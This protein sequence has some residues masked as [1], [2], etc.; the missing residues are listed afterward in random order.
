MKRFREEAVKMFMVLMF[1]LLPLYYSDNYYDILDDKKYIFMLFA[2]ILIVAVAACFVVNMIFDLKKKQ[3]GNHIQAEI[4]SIS[5][6][7]VLMVLFSVIAVISLF[8]A[9]D[10]DMAFSGG[11]AWDVGAYAIV[12]GMIVYFI[13][14]RCFSG[15]ADVWAY[16][17][18]GSF[19]VLLIGV[20]DRLGYDFLVMH[21]EIPLQYN[22]FIS[23]IGNVNFWAAYL[24]MIVPFFMLAPVFIKSR[25][26]RFLTYVFLLTAYFSLFITLTNTTYLGIG[27][28]ALFVIWFSFRDTKRLKN[29]AANGI[30]FTM[31]GAVAEVLWKHPEMTA[32]PIDTDSVSLLLLQHRLYLIPG[33]AGVALFMILFATGELSEE[34]RAK[35][36]SVTEKYIPAVWCLAVLAGVIAACIYLARHYSLELLNYRGSIWYF[37]FHG[38]LDADL[39]QKLIGIGPGLLDIVTQE[40]I[41]K[42]DFFVEWNWYYC[43]AHN[44]LLEYLVTT[45]ILG[46]IVRLLLYIAPFLMFAKGETKKTEKAAVLAALVGFIG[47]GLITGPYILTYVIYIVFLGAMSAYY[48]MGK[49]NG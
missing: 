9:P 32:R 26:Y 22:I 44:D 23:T 5:F 25:F 42:A 18:L 27:V 43:T 34:K 3:L 36:A 19:A 48:R 16:L 10:F 46:C 49:Q 38:F 14:S 20:I 17:Y 1:T 35:I 45:G 28:A 41:A 13:I 40:Q 33:I 39:K 7:D 2:K 31:A 47:Q 4:R 15:K 29:L 6:L 8:F 12:L 24:S 37:A 30:L 11:D 21:D